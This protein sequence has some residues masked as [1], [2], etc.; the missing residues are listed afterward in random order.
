M[1]LMSETND[2]WKQKTNKSISHVNFFEIVGPQ[3][4]V[5]HLIVRQTNDSQRP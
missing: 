3:G 2:G 1:F 4:S 5:D